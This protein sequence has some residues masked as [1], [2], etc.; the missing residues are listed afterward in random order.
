P[1]GQSD[2]YVSPTRRSSDLNVDVLAEDPDATPEDWREAAAIVQRNADR[3]SAM[4]DDLLATARF[5][6]GAAAKTHLDLA[7]LI[8]E[9]AVDLDRKSTRLYSN[10]EKIP[11]A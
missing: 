2:H 3:M 5:E 10:Q 4:I 11:Y 6:V 1:V 7:D 8:A 9:A